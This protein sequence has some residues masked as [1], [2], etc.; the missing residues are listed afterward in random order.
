MC[1][2]AATMGGDGKRGTGAAPERPTCLTGQ[3]CTP[4]PD[5]SRDGRE[6]AIPGVSLQLVTL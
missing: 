3:N 5:R 4:R 1:V 6:K 2:A